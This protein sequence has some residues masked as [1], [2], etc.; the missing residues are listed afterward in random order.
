MDPTPDRLYLEPPG[1]PTGT[2]C[3]SIAANPEQVLHAPFPTGATPSEARY[4]CLPNNVAWSNL[5]SELGMAIAPPMLH[6]A[7]TTG[8]GGFTLSLEAT[9][10]HIN[11]DA[12]DGTGTAYWHQGTQGTVD[13]NTHQF[14]TQ[15]RSPDSFIQVY[16]IKARKG[17]PFGFEIAGVLGYVANTSL[18][19]GGGDVRWALLEGFRAGALQYVP[20]ISLGGGVR[21]L[22]GSS[23]FYLTTVG[24]DA[25]LSKPIPLA[26]SAVLTPYLGAQ[27]I[28]IFA[29]SAAV[30]LTPNVDP[31]AQCG[32]LG[33]NVPGNPN[34]APPFDGSTLCKNK[35]SNGNPNDSDFNNDRT[36]N[37]ARIHRWRGTI[38][39]NYRH[40]LLDVGAEFAMD[41]TEPSA[42]NA[43]LGISGERQ[44]TLSLA[45]GI[46]F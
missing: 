5:M 23:T 42:E 41:L 4:A 10:T 44:W 7:R 33:A 28:I 13:P 2:S 3:Q 6:P 22:S 17:L 31:V 21:T 32:S 26:A 38:G 40:E 20:D 19:V 14:S 27:R 24:L 36:F 29:D 16:S 8:Y 12:V 11:A 25:E 15:N 30:D 43:N 9:F 45:T 39:A 34:A 18:W 46:S 1:L 35:L 37:Q